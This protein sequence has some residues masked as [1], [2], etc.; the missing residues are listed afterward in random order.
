MN[1]GRRIVVLCACLAPGGTFIGCNREAPRPTTAWITP[2]SVRAARRA[3]DGAPPVIPHKPLG[4]ACISCHTNSGK[5]APGIGFAP[6]NPHRVGG[7]MTNCRQCHLFQRGES[8]FVNSDFSGLPVSSKPGDRLFAGAPP[9]IPHRL[10]MRENCLAC[11]DGPAA[12][13]EIRC[14]HPERVNCRQ[15]HVSPATV[16]QFGHV[17]VATTDSDRAG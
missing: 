6:A 7:A 1:A 12:R 16:A 10:A 11:H 8:A 5:E 13:P 4:A 2:T 14:T 15:C 9:T 17:D 3:F